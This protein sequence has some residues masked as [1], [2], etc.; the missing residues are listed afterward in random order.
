MLFGMLIGGIVC[1]AM[2]IDFIVNAGM[3]MLSF[4]FSLFIGIFFGIVPAR[5]AAKL[6]PIDALRSE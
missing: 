5:K 2:S 1:K 6:S 4:M 3:V